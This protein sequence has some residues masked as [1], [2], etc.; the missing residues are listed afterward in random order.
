MSNS[1]TF[2]VQIQGFELLSLNIHP[3]YDFLGHMKGAGPT[4]PKLWGLHDPEQHQDILEGS[5][6][7]PV[8]LVQQKSEASN[9]TNGTLKKTQVKP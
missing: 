5:P 6:E 7:D 1:A 4:D 3:I 9:Q 2:L 8:L